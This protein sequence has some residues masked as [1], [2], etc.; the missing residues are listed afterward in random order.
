MAMGP[1]PKTEIRR[2]LQKVNKTETCWLWTAGKNKK[3][4]GTFSLATR[5]K[6]LAHR[7]SYRRFRGKIPP[8]IC[9]LHECDVPACVRPTHLFLGT[10]LDN[11]EDMRKK[12]RVAR[13]ARHA[14]KT[15]PER[16]ARGQARSPLSRAAVRDIRST[17]RIFGYQTRLAAKYGVAKQTISGIIHRRS[18]GW[19]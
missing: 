2:F 1:R 5:K 12:G 9:V 15:H 3:G 8:G 4:Y 6:V 10:L 19:L 13:G 16:I 7:W 18:W 17:P 14:T 11:N